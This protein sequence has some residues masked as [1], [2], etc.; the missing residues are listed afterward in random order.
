MFYDVSVPSSPNVA[1]KICEQVLH[2]Q[3]KNIM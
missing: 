3:D 1:A 2:Y